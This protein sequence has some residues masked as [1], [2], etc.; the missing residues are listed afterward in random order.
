MKRKAENA[1]GSILMFSTHKTALS[2]TCL[3]GH[4]QKK[5][6]SQPVDHCSVYGLKMQR[7]IL[8]AYLSPYVDPQTETLSIELYSKRINDCR[9]SNPIPRQKSEPVRVN[10]THGICWNP[11]DLSVR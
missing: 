9:F 6:L 3:C 10:E 7:D 8:S 4:K 11:S 5:S 2:Q 1:D